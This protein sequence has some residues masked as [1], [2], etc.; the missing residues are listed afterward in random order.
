MPVDF[1]QLESFWDMLQKMGWEWLEDITTKEGVY[2]ATRYA[3]LKMLRKGTTTVCELVEAPCDMDGVLD[4][5]AKAVDEVGIRAQIGYETT[6][7][8]VGRP[9]LT[10]QKKENADA[11]LAENIRFLKKYPKETG[12]GLKD[13]WACI[14]RIPTVLKH[15]KK[16]GPLRMNSAAVSR[17]TSPRYRARF[18]WRNTAC[19]R[20]NILRRRGLLGPDVVAAHCIDLTDGDMEI[21]A[22][23]GGERRAYAYDQFIG[24]KRRGAR[25]RDAGNGY[26][27]FDGARLLFHAGRGRIYAVRIPGA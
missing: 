1:S 21:L 18:W 19:P 4:V 16:R 22:Q 13:G 27:R 20:R 8:V 5:S 15:L 3:A 2:A 14:R 9:I 6:E 24:W 17:Y 23:S 25:S 10:D 7:R 12:A 11:G 26:K